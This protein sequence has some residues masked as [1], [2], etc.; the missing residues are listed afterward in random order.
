M[1]FVVDA[2]VAVKWFV[3]E[4]FESE[5]VRLLNGSNSF[6]VPDL[7]YPEFCNVIWMKVRRDEITSAEGEQI[8]SAFMK[9]K[10]STYSHNEIIEAA[11]AGATASD[12]TVYDWTYLALAVSLSCEMVTADRKFYRALEPTNLRKNLRWIGDV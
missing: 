4:D 12:E 1:R 3:P 8:V 10:W 6:H 2:S 9:F 5:A 11:F 7:I